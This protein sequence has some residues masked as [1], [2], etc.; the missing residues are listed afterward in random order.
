MWFSF[1]CG[2]VDL[3]YFFSFCNDENDLSV[4]FV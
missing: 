3:R 4:A 2:I 1:F